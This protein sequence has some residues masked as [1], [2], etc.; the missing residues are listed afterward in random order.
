MRWGLPRGP[1][2]AGLTTPSGDALA[3]GDA[4]PG[5]G[6][7]LGLGLVLVLAP[8]RRGA[9]DG[10]EDATWPAAEAWLLVLASKRWSS[11]ATPPRAVEG[12]MPGEPL[13]PPA[14]KAPH[15]PR[16]KAGGGRHASKRGLD[17]WRVQAPL[18]GGRPGAQCAEI[19]VRTCAR[20]V[21]CSS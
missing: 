18:A 5:L 6:L 7:G 20:P 12:R 11:E 9:E 16:D 1:P 19:F 14:S 10:G 13:A 4:L 3:P 2:H 8:A 17:T 15:R 21:A